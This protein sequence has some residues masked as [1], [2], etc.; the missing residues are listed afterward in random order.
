MA[1]VV[2]TIGAVNDAPVAVADDYVTEEDTRLTVSV[3]GVLTNDWDIDGDGLFA[4]PATGPS[5]GSSS[6]NVDGSFTY[7]P[8]DDFSGLDSFTYVANDG[9]MNSPAA[10]VSITVNPVNDAP[11]AVDDA[12]VLTQGS[13]L[14]VNME[15]DPPGQD[16]P[17]FGVLCN[18]FD[19]VEG[20]S[21]TAVL[22]DGPENGSVI[23]N[24]DGSFTYTPDT[25]IYGGDSFTYV[26]ND[27][28]A[29][30]N[31]ATVTIGLPYLHIGLLDP[32][33]PPFPAYSVKRGSVLPA[34]W[35]YA[36][37]V[38]GLVIDSGAFLPEVRLHSGVDCQTGMEINGQVTVLTPG[39]S[40]YQYDERLDIHQLNVD[41]DE[42]TVKECYNIYTFSGLTGQLDG[43]FIFKIKR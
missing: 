5:N 33:R 29:D 22:V 43:P 14:E 8:N 17:V 7:D 42:L 35:Q 25:G 18:D 24:E 23:L 36:D 41:T 37:R 20:D 26:A 28:T 40:T 15:C 9:Q 12:Y 11:V 10:T 2:I 32:W 1:T 27:G 13:S 19:P 31:V 39:N 4:A 21:L 30:S 6:L 34:R 38:T 3:P 16:P